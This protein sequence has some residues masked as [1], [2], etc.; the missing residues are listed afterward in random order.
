LFSC[1]FFQEKYKGFTRS[2]SFSIPVQRLEILEIERSKRS[3]G[4]LGKDAVGL[5][6][7]GAVGSG[8]GERAGRGGGGAAE[9]GAL[10]VLI[11][12]I[13]TRQAV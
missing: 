5:G 7:R 6:R 13:N 10:V 1:A 9:S 8:R 12:L 3:G 11:I 2:G 4:K